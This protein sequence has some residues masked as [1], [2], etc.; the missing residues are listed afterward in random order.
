MLKKRAHSKAN[1]IESTSRSDG[2]PV[3]KESS[4]QTE[5][6]ANIQALEEALSSR[7]KESEGQAKYAADLQEWADS[8]EKDRENAIAEREEAYDE[9]ARRKNDEIKELQDRYDS[10][11]TQ[12]NASRKANDTIHNDYKQIINEIKSKSDEE[13]KSADRKYFSCKEQLDA[14]KA[15]LAG[16]DERTQVAAQEEKE[17]HKLKP[18]EVVEENKVQEL[19]VENQ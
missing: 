3:R 16:G 18:V 7:M 14:L 5:P 4:I 11:M 19:K 9:L 8:V 2:A 13:L 1:E 10:I 17:P 12:L 6:D 15:T